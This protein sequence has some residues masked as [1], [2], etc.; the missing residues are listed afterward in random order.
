MNYFIDFDHTLYNTPLL[1]NEMLSALANIAKKTS[2][3]NYEDIFNN[4]QSK[5]KRGE[6]N[7]YDIYSLINYF[8]NIYNFNAIQA[9][10]IVNKIILNGQ[11]FL[12]DDSIQFL[13]YLK[14]QGHKIYILSYNEKELYFQTLKI[15]GSGILKY[16]NCLTTTL[17]LKGNIPLD[18]SKCIFIDDKPKDLISINEKNPF[19]IYRIRRPNDTYSNEEIEINNSIQEFPSLNAL[20]IELNNN[21]I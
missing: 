1:T 2:N 17:I 4:L 21:I 12:F 3:Q 6:N 10:D 5:F 16:A 11:K 19:K 8:S 13:Q 7:I 9:T 15:A 20:Q 18:F 14:K